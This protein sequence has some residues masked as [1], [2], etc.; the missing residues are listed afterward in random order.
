M[1]LRMRSLNWLLRSRS[2]VSS[3]LLCF[4][5]T[6]RFTRR[7]LGSR[8]RLTKPACSSRSMRAP[9]ATLPTSSSSASSVWGM[10]SLRDRKA[11][12]HHCDR[13][14][15]SGLSHLSKRVRRRRDTS[16]IRYPRRSSRSI[17]GSMPILLGAKGRVE[18]IS[19]EALL[20]VSVRNKFQPAIDLGESVLPRDARPGLGGG[21]IARG[22]P[23]VLPGSNRADPPARLVT[24]DHQ[25]PATPALAAPGSAPA[26]RRRMIFF[27]FIDQPVISKLVSAR[28]PSP[29]R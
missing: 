3:S 14:M 15:P 21:T 13:V 22:L 12:T 29:F 16:W 26:S 19:V 23:K 25:P 6:M 5:S 11:S 10:P 9:S 28:R 24:C 20:Y 18:A 1:P 17:W 7:S 4:V 8:V 27:R 2:V